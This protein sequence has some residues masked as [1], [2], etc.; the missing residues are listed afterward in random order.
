MGSSIPVI[1]NK[2]QDKL[3]SQYLGWKEPWPTQVSLCY[4]VPYL[5]SPFYLL[6]Y[7]TR[8][9]DVTKIVPTRMSF[10]RRPTSHLPIERTLTI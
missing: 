4:Q 9:Q 10:S 1:T 7:V 6:D 3:N 2:Y 5:R 8:R